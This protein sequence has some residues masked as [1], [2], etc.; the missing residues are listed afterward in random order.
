MDYYE[1]ILSYDLK[2]PIY[3]KNEDAKDFM[4]KLLEVDA[5][6]RISSYETIK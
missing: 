3:F 2:F 5:N 1:S 4:S 6:K